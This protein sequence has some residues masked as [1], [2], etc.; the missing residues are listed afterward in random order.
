MTFFDRLFAGDKSLFDVPV[1]EQK[2][3][4]KKLGKAT[5]DFDRSYKQYKGQLF[6]MSWQK[7]CFLALASAFTAPFLISLLIIKGL[8]LRHG[9]K[10][11]AITRAK[12]YEQFI[13][14]S[15]QEMFQIDRDCWWK[16]S[17]A[18][19]PLD[20][21]FVIRFC[22]YN[23][24]S[25]YFA[26]K[27]AYK[28]AKYSSLIHRH[29]PLAIIVHDE[30]SFTS[31]VLTHFCARH[32]VT[33]IDVMHGEKLFSLRDSYFRF[34]KCYV[35]DEHYRNLFISLNAAPEQFVVELPE[36]MKFDLDKHFVKGYYADFKYYLGLYNEQEIATIV[37]SM[38]I[39]MQSG[40][41]VK[42]RPHPNY[43]DMKLLRKYV[44]EEQIELP[45]VNILESISS[46]NNVVG[47]YSTVL[48]QAYYNG[49]NV[50][51]DDISIKNQYE[52][53]KN[54]NYILIDKVS[55]RLS[56]YQ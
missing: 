49:K 27:T 46:T 37:N 8:F 32:H 54:L 48:T 39:F 21:L 33:H 16:E 26:L 13:P 10:L 12:D 7:K 2:D 1:L 23:W 44:K 55:E 5:S 4:L 50:I 51:L 20:V 45:Q 56:V 35:W 34:D 43:S 28:L 14:A 31:S 41:S 18:I 42:F 29:H 47:I 19:S 6:F 40:K 3:Y 15:L 53:L 36:S 17:T 52:S 38:N 25:P 30:F 9:K 11:E 24:H 22:V